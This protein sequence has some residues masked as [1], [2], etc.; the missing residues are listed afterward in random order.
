MKLASFVGTSEK[1]AEAASE[2][3]MSRRFCSVMGDSSEFQWIASQPLWKWIWENIV[4]VHL[5]YLTVL[6]LS[7]NQSEDSSGIQDATQVGRAGGLQPDISR[8]TQ[9]D[10]NIDKDINEEEFPLLK[11]AVTERKETPEQFITLYKGGL[12]TMKQF[13]E[14]VST[15]EARNVT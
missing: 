2:I 6:N 13:L 5:F 7:S 11:L 9:T 14:R 8:P 1:L 12:S 15:T 10:Q 4:D 3:G